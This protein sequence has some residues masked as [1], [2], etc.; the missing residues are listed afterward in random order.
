[1]ARGLAAATRTRPTR[2]GP[3]RAASAAPHGKPRAAGGRPI[4]AAV[5]NAGGSCSLRERLPTL[6]ALTN[7]RGRGGRWA[8]TTAR[9]RR[10]PDNS[11]RYPS[12]WAF[13]EIGFYG[14]FLGDY[15][16]IQSTHYNRAMQ[17]KSGWERLAQRQERFARGQ[18]FVW[19]FY[20][21]GLSYGTVEQSGFVFCIVV[22]C[23]SVGEARA[24]KRQV[25]ARI[26]E[27]LARRS[28]ANHRGDRPHN[29]FSLRPTYPPT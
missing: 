23:R 1:M 19:C 14:S 25:P 7:G 5:R 26:P 9:R 6:S 2:Q 29:L 16:R 17:K 10:R 22:L 13:M 18:D 21:S 12:N 24:F 15:G 8:S 27:A 28:L 4:V 11:S 3:I 20:S